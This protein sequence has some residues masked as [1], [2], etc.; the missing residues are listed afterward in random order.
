MDGADGAPEMTQWRR[1]LEISEALRELARFDAT[2]E[3]KEADG[4]E[5]AVVDGLPRMSEPSRRSST[6]TNSPDAM[7]L[8]PETG[9]AVPMT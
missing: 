5:A 4:D 6:P 7:Q 2:A 8:I 9:D 3:R 1:L